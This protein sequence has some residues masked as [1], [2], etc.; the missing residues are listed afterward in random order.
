MRATTRARG[1]RIAAWSSPSPPART[2]CRPRTRRPRAD[3]LR[4]A[5]KGSGE[6]RALFHARIFLRTYL[7]HR[8]V[9]GAVRDGRKSRLLRAGFADPP[10]ARLDRG[11]DRSPGDQRPRVARRSPEVGADAGGLLVGC[12]GD[13]AYD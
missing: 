9:R 5:S 3:F 1:R 4:V 11:A 2:A 6:S 10:A 13:L 12:G 8:D 7:G